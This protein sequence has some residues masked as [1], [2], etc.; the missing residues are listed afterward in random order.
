MG[1]LPAWML[2]IVAGR[3]QPMMIGPDQEVLGEGA[4]DER[5]MLLKEGRVV[6]LHNNRPAFEL[7]ARLCSRG[8]ADESSTSGRRD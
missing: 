2:R 3:L 4:E 5:L 7:E 1:P 6:A 8:P